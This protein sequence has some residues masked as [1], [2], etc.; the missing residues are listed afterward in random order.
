MLYSLATTLPDYLLSFRAFLAGY[1]ASGSINSQAQLSLAFNYLKET[2]TSKQELDVKIF[3]KSIG[4]GIK[5]TSEEIDSKILELFEERKAELTDKRYTIN[6]GDYMSKLRERLPFADGALLNQNFQKK[7]AEVLGPVT[8]ADLKMK[9]EAKKKKPNPPSLKPSEEKKEKEAA[10]APEEEDTRD[11]LKKL[12]ARD[13]GSS[14]NSAEI[15]RKHAEIAGNKIYTRFPP[16]PNGYLHIGH[17]KAM[18]FNFL[19]AKEAN[20]HCYLRFDDTNPDKENKEYI[21]NIKK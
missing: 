5:I 7:L 4:V 1:I 3:E 8:E 6:M 9:E 19:S 18:R 20:G 12:M 2:T 16:E 17:A 10:A 11:K 15:L 14:L 13:L 21:E